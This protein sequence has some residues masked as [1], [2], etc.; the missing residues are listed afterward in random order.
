MLL[1]VEVRTEDCSL[2]CGKEWSE[3]N[4]KEK[5][6]YIQRYWDNGTIVRFKSIGG[7]GGNNDCQCR[8]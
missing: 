1:N 8:A 2:I 3:M 6:D 7:K 5:T 4:E